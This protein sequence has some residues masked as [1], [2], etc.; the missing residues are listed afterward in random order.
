MP[1]F[2]PVIP[3]SHPGTDCLA[4]HRRQSGNDS[5]S[6]PPIHF[7]AAT[8]QTAISNTCRHEDRLLRA[9]PILSTSTNADTGGPGESEVGSILDPNDREIKE[10]QAMHHGIAD[11]PLV[12]P[13][14]PSLD[15]HTL[16][17]RPRARR[18]QRIRML[19]V[20]RAEKE[21]GREGRQQS[22]MWLKGSG[23][24]D[25]SASAGR[26]PPAH[27]TEGIGATRSNRSC[28]SLSFKSWPTL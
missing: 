2:D 14:F 7:H 26:F 21:G 19:P 20:D 9:S 5:R 23:Y 27:A 16:S 11:H 1:G 15:S 8:C 10:R 18:G 13:L 12:H 25:L 17:P 28:A 3:P 24:L 22:R 6:F 4:V